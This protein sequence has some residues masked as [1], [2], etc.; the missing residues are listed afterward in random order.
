M[1]HSFPVAYATNQT[2]PTRNTL[3]GFEFAY[4]AAAVSVEY[5]SSCSAASVRSTP[6]LAGNENVTIYASW[7]Y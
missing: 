6:P 2:N 7:G 4:P 5:G 1:A 3:R